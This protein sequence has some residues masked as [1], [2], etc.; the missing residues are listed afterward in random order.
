MKGLMDVGCFNDQTSDNDL[1]RTIV[2]SDVVL[3]DDRAAEI[4]ARR[5]QSDRRED[6]ESG[7]WDRLMVQQNGREQP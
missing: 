1:L 7:E 3:I 2:K 6:N 5:T 4:K